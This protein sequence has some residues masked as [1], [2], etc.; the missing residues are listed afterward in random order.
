[1]RKMVIPF[2]PEMK[3]LL[4]H[5]IKGGKLLEPLFKVCV[6]KHDKEKVTST[7][8]QTEQ[9]SL[10]SWLL[11]HADDISQVTQ[12]GMANDQMMCEF[13]VEVVYQSLPFAECHLLQSI[14][15]H[16]QRATLCMT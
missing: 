10:M 6:E 7:D 11:N 1:M 15:P 8:F 5:K 9:G 4:Y 3:R 2:L 14:P 13:F 12:L 16:R